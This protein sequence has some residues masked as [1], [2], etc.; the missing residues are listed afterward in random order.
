MSVDT[1]ARK[2]SLATY[3]RIRQGDAEI[4]VSS[5]LSGRVSAVRLIEKKFLWFRWLGVEASLVGH[6]T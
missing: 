1:Y 4:L 3:R 5:A 6:P 2:K